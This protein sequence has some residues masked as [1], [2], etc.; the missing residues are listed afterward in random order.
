MSHDELLALTLSLKVA[1]WATFFILVP[2]VAMAWLLARKEFLAKP[3]LDA[4]V[5]LPLVL[6]PVVPGYGLLL[7]LGKE[8][9]LGRMLF[10]FLGIR[11]AFTWQGAAVASAIMAFPLLV[12]T[13]R[14]AIALVD[15]RI[16]EAARTLGS[17]PWRVFYS[18]TLPLA[19]P[20]VGTGAV[21]AFARSLGEFGATITFAGNIPGETRTLALAIYTELQMPGG[22]GAAGRLTLFSLTLAFLALLIS[23][24]VSKRMEKRRS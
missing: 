22:E 18:M 3:L 1:L 23:D 20:G 13:A 15:P 21:L 2:G 4:M 17:S 9:L 6:P 11:L 14:L 12:R 5:H 10:D 8:G 16:E 24:S 7:L 19:L